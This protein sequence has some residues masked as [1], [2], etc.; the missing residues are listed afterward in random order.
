[1]SNVKIQVYGL[2]GNWET[3]ST[4]PTQ[5]S[6]GVRNA[7]VQAVKSGAARYQKNPRARA[8]DSSGMV[9]DMEIG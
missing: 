5:P 9:V 7:L 6:Y 2:S 4:I 3:I 8:V 1:M